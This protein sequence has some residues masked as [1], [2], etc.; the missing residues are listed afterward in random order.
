MI[1]EAIE[2]DMVAMEVRLKD[3]NGNS[4]VPNNIFWSLYDTDENIINNRDNISASSLGKTTRIVLKGNDLTP[5]WRIFFIKGN[6]DSVNG[7]NL[8]FTESLKF[9]VKESYNDK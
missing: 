5:G 8:P 9:Y 2:G 6:Y 7:K 3:E 1:K 4:V